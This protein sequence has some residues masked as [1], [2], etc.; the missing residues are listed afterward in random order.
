MRDMKRIE[1]FMAEMASIWKE[2]FPDYRFGQLMVGFFYALGDPFYYEE[3]VLLEA[4]KAYASGEDPKEAAKKMMEEK[5]K[6]NI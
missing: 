6:S 1:P 4:F 2:R 5:R 3:D